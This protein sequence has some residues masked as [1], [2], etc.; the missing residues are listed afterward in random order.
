MK[1]LSPILLSLGLLDSEI[2]T[3]LGALT[4]GPST[5]IDLAKATKLSR[6]ATYT[7]ISTLTERGLMSSVERGK[8]SFY[9]AEEPEKLLAY[10]KR[11]ETDVKDKV[12]DLEANLGE[13]KL[14]RGGERPVVRMYEGKAGLKAI[15]EEMKNTGFETSSEI[16]DLDALYGILSPDDL[17]EMR[18]MLKRRG[19]KSRGLLAGT[20]SAGIV[21]AVRVTL[22]EKYRGF[23]ADVGVFG[24]K[25]ELIT[26]EGKMYSVIVES[27]PLAR[28]MEILFDL[29]FKG[30]EAEKKE[31]EKR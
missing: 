27:A 25:V 28:T 4:S 3:Y 19:T 15:I 5:V 16:A 24:D 26:F 14:Q 11:R 18:N 2:K 10:A 8:K 13:L 31:S 7:A 17:L 23:K 6:Q 1:D 12:K 30:L 29:A 21:D 20:P 9:A 22:P